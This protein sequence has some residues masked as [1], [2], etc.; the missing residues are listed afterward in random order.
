[1]IGENTPEKQKGLSAIFTVLICA[2]NRILDKYERSRWEVDPCFWVY[3]LNAGP[4]VHANNSIGSPLILLNLLIKHT[5]RRCKLILFE[6]DHDRKG[7]FIDLCNNI[8]MVDVPKRIEVHPIKADHRDRLSSLYN[9]SEKK[10]FGLCYQDYSG[11]P[12]FDV[13]SKFSHKSCNSK[14]DILINCNTTQI[15]RN[16]GL[17]KNGNYTVS[18][19][20]RDP[21][22]AIKDIDKQ[23]WQI[24]EPLGKWQW[25]MLLGTNWK[26][27]STFKKLGFEKYE[28]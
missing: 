14:T 9:G 8:N 18:Q 20:T 17:S 19:E 10:R 21:I 25:Q 5:K 1:M 11:T 6:N 24:R 27:L 3:D 16:R 12:N 2:G 4:G 28:K 26:A 7:N 15:K 22:E 23:Y 13:L